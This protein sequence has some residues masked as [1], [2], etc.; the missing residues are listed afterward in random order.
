MP[1]SNTK[2]TDNRPTAYWIGT[3]GCSELTCSHCGWA[4]DVAIRR[5]FCPNCGCYMKGRGENNADLS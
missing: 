4:H 2:E 1:D 3:E 5:V